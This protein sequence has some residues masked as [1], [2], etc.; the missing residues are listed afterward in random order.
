MNLTGDRSGEQSAR[1]RTGEDHAGGGMEL[2]GRRMREQHALGEGIGR[3]RCGHVV[4]D[5]VNDMMDHDGGGGARGSGVGFHNDE[6]WDGSVGAPEIPQQDFNGLGTYQNDG[7]G[8]EV[9]TKPRSTGRAADKVEPP[10][11]GH[12]FTAAG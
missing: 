7:E 2:S 8:G 10:D 1:R 11:L 9:K 3:L 4:H 12:E 5:V 6:E